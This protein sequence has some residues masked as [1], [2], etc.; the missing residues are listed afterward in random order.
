[1]H[2]NLWRQESETIPCLITCAF[3]LWS[4]EDRGPLYDKY[5]FLSIIYLYLRL[6]T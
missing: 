4:L 3:T 2:E 5:A 6:F 1:M